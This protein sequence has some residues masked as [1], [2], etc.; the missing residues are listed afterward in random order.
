[1]TDQLTSVLLIWH[2]AAAT[3]NTQQQDT[4][5]ATSRQTDWDSDTD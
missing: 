1:M 2:A 5:V 4:L 3:A